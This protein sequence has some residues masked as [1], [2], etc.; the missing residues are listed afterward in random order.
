MYIGVSGSN[1][2]TQ[3]YL[4]DLAMRHPEVVEL[5]QVEG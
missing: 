5:E 3:D 2:D 1:I 4:K